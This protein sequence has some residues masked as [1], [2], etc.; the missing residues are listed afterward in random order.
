MLLTSDRR[1][2][3]AARR[4][5]QRLNLSPKPPRRQGDRR[6]SPRVPRRLLV[7]DS[8][9]ADFAL[10]AGDVSLGGARWRADRF[11]ENGRVEIRFHLPNFSRLACATARV[12]RAELDDDTL[13]LLATYED[14]DVRAEL[15]L[16]RFLE[17]RARLAADLAA[18]A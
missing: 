15:A 16:A 6:E 10:C 9:G 14:L 5:P 4:A 8:A 13:E 3:A 12:V 18:G 7:R 1:T 11:P 2:R 17:D